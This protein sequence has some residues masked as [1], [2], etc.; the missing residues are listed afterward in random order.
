MAQPDDLL[1]AD[2]SELTM[3]GRPVERAEGQRP[4]LE[5]FTT[6]IPLTSETH[7][8]GEWVS[9][10]PTPPHRPDIY[11]VAIVYAPRAGRILE[12]KSLREYGLW[13]KT[14]AADAHTLARQVAHEVLAATLALWVEVT[15]RNT[16]SGQGARTT[17]RASDDLVHAATAEPTL[18][19]LVDHAE[20][21]RPRLACV[22]AEV[23]ASGQGQTHQWR[24]ESHSW[25]SQSPVPPYLTD[26]YHVTIAYAPH[27]GRVLEAASLREYGASFS[28]TNAFAEALAGQVAHDVLAATGADW[29]EVTFAQNVR[30]GWQIEALQRLTSGEPE[31]KQPQ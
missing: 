5:C 26:I 14:T 20:G 6:R 2:T 21:Q 8:T 9:L 13:W 22:T 16:G 24:H 28:G 19:R 15:F 31:P 27:G 17:L 18:G 23:A 1:A 29:V 10:S 4:G 12:A 3:L 7:R 30:G 25:V 11:Q